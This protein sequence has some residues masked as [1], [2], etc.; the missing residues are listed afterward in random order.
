M[1]AD[2]SGT[3]FSA[4]LAAVTGKELATTLEPVLEPDVLLVSDGGTSYPPCAAALKVSHEP[5]NLSAGERVRGDLHIQTVN[6][7]HSLLKDFLRRRRGIASKYL[8][9]YLRWF[10]MVILNPRPTQR[11]CLA[12]AM[13][14]ARI[15]LAN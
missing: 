6:N 12:A 15:Q 10:H 1:A 3:T 4:V 8:G 11:T 9:S 2:R 5:L 14:R 13:T 7:R